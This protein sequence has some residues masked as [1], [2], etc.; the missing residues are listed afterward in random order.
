MEWQR[1]WRLMLRVLGGRQWS[2]SL[3]AEPTGVLGRQM[4][5]HLAKE[6]RELLLRLREQH[7][8]ASLRVSHRHRSFLI[9]LGTR[10]GALARR[11]RFSWRCV[12]QH[13]CRGSRSRRRV[14]AHLT[15]LRIPVVRV[16]SR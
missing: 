4:L 6:F 16:L 14:P 2:L 5:L 9:S 1:E 15:R 3:R 12:W 11:Y 10:A 8:R 13:A 7:L